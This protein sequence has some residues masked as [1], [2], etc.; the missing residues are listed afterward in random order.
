MGNNTLPDLYDSRIELFN[1]KSHEKVM[2]HK[3]GF[4]C[5]IILD[6]QFPIFIKFSLIVLMSFKFSER[7]RQ[8]YNKR[9]KSSLYI[10]FEDGKVAIRI[11]RKNQ[12]SHLYVEYRDTSQAKLL[13]ENIIPIIANESDF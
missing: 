1:K 5:L 8:L 6:S 13:L 10:I 4:L 7:D 3:D 9:K 11:Q 12:D 2:S